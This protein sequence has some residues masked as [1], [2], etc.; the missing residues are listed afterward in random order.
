MAI[1]TVHH[2]AKWKKEDL[3]EKAIG[4]RVAMRATATTKNSRGNLDATVV[5]NQAVTLMAVE[6]ALKWLKANLKMEAM[7][8]VEAVPY[9]ISTILTLMQSLHE[10]LTKMAR[11]RRG[12]AAT[13]ARYFLSGYLLK[14]SIS[15]KAYLHES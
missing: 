5:V 11:Y 6:V 15:R 12:D 10:T 1:H 14:N 9:M 7:I 8:V 3:I 2:F 13:S 4:I